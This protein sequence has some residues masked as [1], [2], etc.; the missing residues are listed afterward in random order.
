MAEENKKNEKEEKISEDLRYKYIGF[1]I[2]PKKVKD[3]WKDE[4]E[5][6]EH[7][8]KVKGEKSQATLLD[9]DQ[10]LVRIS[11]F[12]KTDKIVLSIASFLL[13]ISLF[14]PW[15]SLRGENLHSTYTGL[16]FI[17]KLGVLLGYAPLGGFLLS[18]FLVLLLLTILSS[19]GVGVLNLV[20]IYKKHHNLERYLANLKRT[21]KLNLIPLSLWV[22]LIIIT[23]IGM[24]TPFAGA[25]LGVESW[26]DGFNV[27]NFLALSSYG[28]WLGLPC[29]II[30]CV[31]ISDL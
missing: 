21:L 9:R 18:L 12:S 1:D 19:F 31:K 24:P 3:F 2:F 11:V 15:F 23:I 26:G 25:L 22:I 28:M 30:N 16:G 13:A 17:F 5:K 10:S 7:L 14:I 8:E 4:E 6:R 20:S 27:I 29:L